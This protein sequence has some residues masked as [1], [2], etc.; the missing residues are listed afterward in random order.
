MLLKAMQVEFLDL[1]VIIYVE[2][3]SFVILL[4]WR[5]VLYVVN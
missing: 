3:A 1:K 2:L 5:C 4:L